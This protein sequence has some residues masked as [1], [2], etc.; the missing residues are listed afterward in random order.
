[1]KQARDG[2]SALNDAL[3]DGRAWLGGETQSLPDLMIWPFLALQER[4]GAAITRDLACAEA[5]WRRARNLPAFL[6]TR[7]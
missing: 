4:D 2:H 5:Y 1:M 6:S 7:P 3:S